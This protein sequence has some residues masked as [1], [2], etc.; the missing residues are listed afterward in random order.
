MNIFSV[1]IHKYVIAETINELI[2]VVQYA[3]MD[4][5][6]RVQNWMFLLHFHLLHIQKVKQ[7]YLSEC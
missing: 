3:R 2:S 6:K 5:I 1:N 4:L 7:W